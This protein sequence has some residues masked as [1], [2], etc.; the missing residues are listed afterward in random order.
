MSTTHPNTTTDATTATEDPTQETASRA[1]DLLNTRQAAE[2]LNVSVTTM[3]RM[4]QARRFPVV[5]FGGKVE[6]ILLRVRRGDLDAYVRS[7]I[8]PAAN[9]GGDQ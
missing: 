1:D 3:R 4:I 9:D 8:L 7:S 2:V 5:R 6:G